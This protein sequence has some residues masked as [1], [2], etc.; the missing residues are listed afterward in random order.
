MH[1]GFIK[2]AVTD[3][4]GWSAPATVGAVLRSGR[5]VLCA[6]LGRCSLLAWRHRPC[7]AGI[8][9]GDGACSSGEVP[10][11]GHW[12]KPGVLRARRGSRFVASNWCGAL[13]APVD[14]YWLHDRQPYCLPTLSL[15]MSAGTV[16]V[17]T[18]A[19]G[20]AMR[21]S[22]RLD[23]RMRSPLAA[24]PPRGAKTRCWANGGPLSLCITGCEA[25]TSHTKHSFLSTMELAS[26]IG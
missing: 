24:I 15:G 13:A 10:S 5:G 4:D 14:S 23:C 21:S 18:M 9:Q 17:T 1:R 8:G 20:V 19:L 25:A 6:V 22:R 11:A 3:R 26:P 16:W 12:E 2:D 7:R